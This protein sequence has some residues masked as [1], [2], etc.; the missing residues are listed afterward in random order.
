MH[1]ENEREEPLDPVQGTAKPTRYNVIED[2][3]NFNI[4]LLQ[5]LS[6]NLCHMFPPCNGAVSYPARAYLAQLVAFRGRSK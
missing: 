5:K 2:D 6:Y 1:A 4:D 3:A